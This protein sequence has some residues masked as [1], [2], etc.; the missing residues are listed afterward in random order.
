MPVNINPAAEIMAEFNRAVEVQGGIA[1]MP[2]PVRR[3]NRARIDAAQIQP[4]RWDNVDIGGL[5]IEQIENMVFHEADMP[6][7]MVKTS[8]T[9]SQ[10]VPP[11]EP[12]IG[13]HIGVG[14]QGTFGI[15]VEVEGA[16]LLKAIAGKWTD[17]DDGSLRGESREYVLRKPLKLNEAKASI[18]DLKK[19]LDKNKAVLDF[20]FRTSVHVHVNVLDMTKKELHC[21][22]YLSHLF[23]DALVNYSG[24]PRV[25]NRFCL[26]CCDAEYK[27]VS[28]FSFF[29]EKSGFRHLNEEHLKYSAINIAPVATQGSVEFRSMRG[30]LDENVLHPWL[31]VLANLKIIAK[32]TTVAELAK[33]ASNSPNSL[34]K[35][36]FGPHLPVFDYPSIKD[37]LRKNYSMLIE[38]PYLKVGN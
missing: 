14:T 26:R 7:V 19:A 28:M 1:A 17:K 16:N 32:E 20:S 9:S 8:G 31:D 3:V 2:P 12:T 36:V 25:G 34:I 10:T 13:Q 21:F 38:M 33:E 29:K 30:T 6:D 4:I 22:L 24:H 23:E 11:K 5:N 35:K 15:E 37:D 18:I 27:L